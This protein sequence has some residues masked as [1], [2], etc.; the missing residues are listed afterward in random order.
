MCVR[1]LPLN[2]LAN[3]VEQRLP[4]E[5]NSRVLNKIAVFCGNPRFIAM[6]ITHHQTLLFLQPTGLM[7]GLSEVFSAKG[8]W[9]Q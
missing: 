2:T 1:H 4:W 9:L 5:E 7:N 6:F 8:G 3:Y